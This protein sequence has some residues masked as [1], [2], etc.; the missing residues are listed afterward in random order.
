[1]TLLVDQAKRQ[2]VPKHG[3]AAVAEDDFVA[4]WQLKE[5]TQTITQFADGLFDSGLAVTGAEVGGRHVEEVL[6]GL[7][8]N[9]RRSAAK[10]AIGREEVFRDAD[11]WKF[12]HH[13]PAL[14]NSHQLNLETALDAGDFDVSQVVDEVV[15]AAELFLGRRGAKCNEHPVEVKEQASRFHLSNARPVHLRHVNRLS[16]RISAVSE[17][18][19]LAIDAKAKALKAAGEPVISFGAGEPDFPTP[20][21]I[22]DAAVAAAKDPKNHRYTP[23]SGLPE[24]RQAV[25]EKTKRDSGYEVTAS[26]VL[27]TN[28]GK[29][30]VEHACMTLIDPGDDVILPAPYWTTYPELIKLAGGNP[31]VIDTDESTGFKATVEKLE[32][33]RTP[34]TKAVVFVS[35]SNP[36]G[37]VYTRDEIEVVGK[38]AVEHGIWVITDEIYE[39][40][41]FG[42]AEFHSMPAVVP[43]VANQCVIIN[44]VAKTF[45]M[46]GWR[47]GWLIGPEDVIKAAGNRHSHATSN[48][49]NVAQRAALAA[50]T[51]DLSAVE[52][53]REVFDRR[54]KLILELIDKVDGMTCL[55]PEGAFYAYAN[56]KG[57]LGRTVDGVT[58]QTSFELA[59]ML[60][61]KV[62]VAIVPGEAFGTPG[63]LRFSYAISDE[64]ITEGVERI[65]KLYA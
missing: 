63:Y 11:L 46:T 54:R 60:L 43:E 64:A 17:S 35:P 19:T 36:T 28:G 26:Q 48:V 33:A 27:I 2:R 9:L 16:Q 15:G 34:K 21:H 8:A 51:G 3:R 55:E 25:A 58:P 40:L 62:K 18:V 56:V 6:D 5:L 24:L 30:A 49:S 4:L 65:A 14:Q 13:P 38:W 44:G 1:M 10:A 45:A 53:M 57:M 39:H 32:A 47:V 31:V 50:V 29:Q 12:A 23:T 22:V 7:T 52:E 41:T 59:E 37:A 20:S 42:D 61:D